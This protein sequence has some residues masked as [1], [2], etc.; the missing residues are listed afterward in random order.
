MKPTPWLIRQAG[1][2]RQ[3]RL[4]CFCYAGGSAVSFM[5]WQAAI[6]PSI[7]ICA[8]QLPGRGARMAEQPYASIP[9]LVKTLAPEIAQRSDLPFAFFGHSLG[10]LLAFEVAR[11]CKLNYM[12]MPQHLFVSACNAP[13]HRNPPE[14][15]HLL[16]DDAFIEKLGSYNGSPPEVLRHRELMEV[17]LPSIRADFALVDGYRYRS[18]VPL[19]MP[20]TV[21]AGKRDTHIS[22]E[23]IAGWRKETNSTC[24]IRWFEGDH[25]FI[26][27]DREAVL[28]CIGAELAE[29][30]C[31]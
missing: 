25:F 7:E 8:I 23:Q 20:I 5:P 10:G 22:P 4:F 17:M 12:A 3:M 11:Y 2:S 21:L 24:C 6:D 30:L 29:T 14:G 27:S 16:A 18:N 15:L 26:H 28:E 1:P 19:T 13:Q 9:D 31:A